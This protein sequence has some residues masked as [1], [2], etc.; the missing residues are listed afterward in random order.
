MQ[1]GPTESSHR[2][3]TCSGGGP[4]M[5]TVLLFDE[6]ARKIALG[7]K[8]LNSVKGMW[9]QPVIYDYNDLMN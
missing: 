6:P 1:L 8:L 4:G 3:K 5:C 2:R 7:L 9:Y